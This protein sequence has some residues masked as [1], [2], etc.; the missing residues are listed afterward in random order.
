MAGKYLP[1][2][3]RCPN[4]H[5]VLDDPLRESAVHEVQNPR[6]SLYS[7]TLESVGW[8][9]SYSPS[10]R[11]PQSREKRRLR[12][13]LLS[14]MATHLHRQCLPQE[15]APT[16]CCLNVSM[17]SCSDDVSSNIPLWGHSPSKDTCRHQSPATES[18]R[19]LACANGESEVW[20]S[21]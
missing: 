7:K 6:C 10:G 19:S 17:R 12:Q 18:H 2:P 21:G 8:S 14:E 20:G 9:H 1:P 5:L 4:L 15:L 16:P 13:C 11:S 3:D